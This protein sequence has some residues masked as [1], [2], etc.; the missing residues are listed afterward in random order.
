MPTA[1]T[2][3]W[4]GSGSPDNKT[5]LEM[6]DDAARQIWGGDWR[7]PTEAEYSELINNCTWTWN[8]NYNSS[9][10]AGYVVSGNGN[11]IFLPAAGDRYGTNLYGQGSDGD[12]WSSSLG[13]DY[14][15]SGRD[16]DFNSSNKSMNSYYRYR[17]RSVRAV[18][19]K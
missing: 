12:Y 15:C 19:S 13:T 1:K 6:S 16:L 4:A 7:M 5:V 11:S 9:G 14:P 17:G 3:Y 18:L 8:S 10:I 2:S